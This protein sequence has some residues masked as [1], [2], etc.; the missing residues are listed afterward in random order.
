M[1]DHFN[2]CGQNDQ[3]QKGEKGFS[4]CLREESLQRTKICKACGEGN[5]AHN[6]FKQGQQFLEGIDLKQQKAEHDQQRKGRGNIGIDVGDT[7]RRPL[8]QQTAGNHQHTQQ[9]QKCKCRFT[10]SDYSLEYSSY[11]IFCG[12]SGKIGITQKTGLYYIA[13]INKNWL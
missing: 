4:R 7:A 5:A 2:Q 1:L 9:K 12:N 11:R 6:P 8:A 13:L 3:I 10:H